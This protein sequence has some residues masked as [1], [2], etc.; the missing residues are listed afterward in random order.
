M[1][2]QRKAL[3]TSHKN[4]RKKLFSC[5]LILAVC[6]NIILAMHIHLLMIDAPGNV[7][8]SS[9]FLLTMY[10]GIPII[11]TIGCVLFY[12]L[13][14]HPDGKIVLLDIALTIMVLQWIL[15][16]EPVIENSILLEAAY[17]A[18]VLVTVKLK[19]AETN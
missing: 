14:T 12:T 16:T 9:M 4:Y 15:Q 6:A 19:K 18:I 8:G 17:A 5:H 10:L 3:I 7:I 11:I 1:A 2:S 13:K